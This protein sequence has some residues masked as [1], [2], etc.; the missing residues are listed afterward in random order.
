MVQTF[1][2]ICL[3]FFLISV[4]ILLLAIL[5]SMRARARTLKE[6]SIT[7]HLIFNA[8]KTVYIKKDKDNYK[9]FDE[10]DFSFLVL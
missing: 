5:V 9:D 7:M 4:P 1:I 8:I 10:E 3:C 2:I 6:L